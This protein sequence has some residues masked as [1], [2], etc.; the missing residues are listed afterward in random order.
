MRAYVRAAG[1]TPTRRRAVE[2]VALGAAAGFAPVPCCLSLIPQPRARGL[3]WISLLPLALSL[4]VASSLLEFRLWDLEGH[5]AP[6]RRDRCRRPCSAGPA[7]FLNYAITRWLPSR[8]LGEFL[9]GR[10]PPRAS[11]Q[12]SR[13]ARQRPE[14]RTP[15]AAATVSP[16]AAP[17]DGCAEEAVARA[18]TRELLRLAQLLR[19]ALGI[20]RVVTYLALG[21]RPRTPPRGGAAA[22]VLLG[23]TTPAS[24]RRPTTLGRRLWHRFRW[25]DRQISAWSTAGAGAATSPARPRQAQAGRRAR[26]PRRPSLSTPLLM[27]NPRSRSAAPGGLLERIFQFSAAALLI[28]DTSPAP[29]VRGKRTGQVTLLCGGIRSS[30]WASSCTP[31]S[32]CVARRP[33]ERPGGRAGADS[34]RRRMARVSC[35]PRRSTSRT[36]GRF[37]GRVVALDDLTDELNLEQRLSEQE[38]LRLAR[39]PGGRPR[40][41]G[42]TPGR[43]EDGV[44]RP[45]PPR[46][47]PPNDPRSPLALKLEEQAVPC[48]TS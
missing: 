22:P 44:V 2:W 14:A 35:R 45:A 48:P 33:P 23:W 40:P 18:A 8:E 39:P 5:H 13:P 41:R 16:P 11:W 10:G 36:P 12:R 29:G 6:G 30:S 32:S 3:T 28:C 47:H 34:P 7:S 25:T 15:A 37:D 42:R 46:A 43:R 19:D 21:G 24:R 4:G 31:W 17:D 9:R 27:A 1:E 20:E 38:R 26:L